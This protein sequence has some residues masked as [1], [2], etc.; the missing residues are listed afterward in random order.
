MPSAFEVAPS[1][2]AKCRGCRGAIAKD[3]LRFGERMENPFGDGEMT[4]W[5]HP[6]CG[7]LYRPEA[8]LETLARTGEEIPDRDALVAF[9]EEGLAHRRLPRLHDVQR[10]PTGRA[11][12]RSCRTLIAKD[13]WR[14]ALVYYQEGR[15]EPSG[16]IHARC[17]M[18]YFETVEILPR[19]RR[20][21]EIAPADAEPLEAELRRPPETDGST[22]S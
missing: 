4:L 21:R 22:G 12:C 20:F 1:G 13:T 8:F 10:A 11:R 9:A 5:F 19:L 7:A 6:A 17:A 18:P 15:F 16:Y 3:T 2:R 14:I